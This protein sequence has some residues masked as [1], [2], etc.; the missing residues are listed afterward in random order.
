MRTLTAIGL[1]LTLA[2]AAG[3]GLAMGGS[4]PAPSSGAT[5]PD[6]DYAK[7]EKAVNAK[8]FRGAIPLLEKIVASEPK[9]ADAFNYLGYSHRKL[10]E[11]EKALA[12]YKKAL[13]IEPNHL[14]ANE[15]L[16]ELYLEM[17]DLANAETRLSTLDKVCKTC[18]ATRE[19]H[20]AVEKFKK[21]GKSS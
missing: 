5:A 7:A 14:G 18:E 8:D 13:E 10:G 15:Y 16:G 19:L 4:S 6:S 9:H 17:G 2:L 12:Y 20:E 3:D 11:K 1:A 21:T